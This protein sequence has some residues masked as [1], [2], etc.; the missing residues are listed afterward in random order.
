MEFL[1]AKREKG[2]A[3]VEVGAA[4]R[5]LLDSVLVDDYPSLKP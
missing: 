2:E 1:A 3:P 4:L 5:N